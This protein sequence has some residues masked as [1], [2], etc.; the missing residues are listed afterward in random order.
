MRIGIV[1]SETSANLAYSEDIY[2]K[3]FMAAQNQAMMAGIPFD[4]LS[5]AD[6]TDINKVRQY[7]T[8]LFPSF[9][10]AAA[11]KIE[12]IKTTLTT[13]S[14]TYGIGMVVQ[15]EFLTVGQASPYDSMKAI[16]GLER[17]GGA[18][19]NFT[20]AA[21]AGHPVMQGYSQ[22]ENLGTYNLAYSFYHSTNGTATT[23]AD[24]VADGQRVPA[25]IA[26]QTGGRNVHFATDAVMGDNNV[27]SQA[28]Q[29]SVHGGG[30]NVTLQMSR[31][32]ALVAARVDMD[33]SQEHSAVAPVDA[34]GQPLLGINDKMLPI[35][36]QWKKDF[37]FVGSFYVNIGNDPADDRFTDW[38]VSGPSYQ[39]LLALGNEIGTHSYTHPDVTNSLTPQQI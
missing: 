10:A 14:Q 22:D 30:P 23:L 3:L 39:K 28:L 21:D 5:E 4:I 7:D 35:I 13:A 19:A 18:V 24:I 25:I 33:Y 34:N 38:T 15:G 2:S 36:E 31:Q 20:L 16:L 8:L 9:Q 11:D 32:S 6:L 12:A 27:L 37:N 29:W 17:A 1:Y 26:T